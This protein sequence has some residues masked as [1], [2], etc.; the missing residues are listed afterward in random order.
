M[1]SVHF[2]YF[3]AGLH[4]QGLIYCINKNSTQFSK[5][6]FIYVNQDKIEFNQYGDAY[7][8]WNK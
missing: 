3:M 5:S 8:N 6:K 1:K 4:K 7:T 2:Y